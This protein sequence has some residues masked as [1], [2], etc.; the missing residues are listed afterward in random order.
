M[1]K[2]GD[3][4]FEIRFGVLQHFGEFFAG[5]FTHQ[6]QRFFAVGGLHELFQRFVAFLFRLA[7][8]IHHLAADED[9]NRYSDQCDDGDVAAVVQHEG[10]EEADG[11]GG[12][13]SDEP[14][15][16]DAQNACD[17]VDGGVTSP[18]TVGERRTHCYHEGDV[19]GRER[20]FQRRSQGDEQ[21]GE[22]EVDRGADEVESGSVGYD[23]FVFAETGVDPLLRA[24]GHD[25]GGAVGK[26][27]AETYQCACH[28]GTSEVLFSFIL[29]GEVYRGFDDGVRLFGGAEGVDHDGAGTDKE[30][31]RCLGGA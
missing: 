20:Q 5:M 30:V 16:D 22:D 12:S 24:F 28:R 4:Q 17:A 21:P 25:A 31:P 7:F 14:A 11:E 27:H 8:L 18:C 2:G 26:C 6:L 3:G 1:Y 19:G 15:T 29:T 9:E 10:Y 13:G 23:G